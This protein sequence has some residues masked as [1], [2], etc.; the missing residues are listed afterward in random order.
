MI[1]DVA[2]VNSFIL[3]VKWQ[4]QH[5]DVPELRRKKGNTKHL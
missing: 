4:E 2:V 5:P 3:F 1:K